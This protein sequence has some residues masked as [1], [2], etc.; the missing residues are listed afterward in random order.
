MLPS[1]RLL[2]RFPM[3]SAGKS[4]LSSCSSSTST[5]SSRRTAA[6]HPSSS[7][8]H[9]RRLHVSPAAAA[10]AAAGQGNVPHTFLFTSES[11]T[12]GHPDKIC[13]QVSDAVLDAS[14]EQDPNSKVACETAVKDN[15]MLV[16]GEITSNAQVDYDAVARQVCHDIGYNSDDLG[17]NASNME[18]KVLIRQQVPEIAQSVHGMG[19]KSADE[20]GAGDQGH[21]FGYASDETPEQMPLSHM[22]ASQLAARLAEVRKDGTCPWARPDGKTQVTIEYLRDGGHLEPLRVHTLLISTQHSPDIS[23]S[24]VQ[25]ELM[26]HVVTPVIPQRLLAPDTQ[27]F[28][29]PSK[30]FILG[31]PVGDAGLTGRKIIVDTYGGWGAHGGGA[32]SGKD[33]TKVDR[34]AAYIAR[35]AAKSVVAA[36]LAN[37]CQVQVS[38]GIGLPHPLSVYVDT[39]KTGKLPDEA[40]QEAVMAMFDFRPG[41]IMQRLDLQRGGN[42]RYQ[43]TA[44]YGH[45][46]RNHDPD[47]SWEKVVPLS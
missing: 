29:N 15:F 44:A 7:A 6:V 22:L 25:D 47:F 38:Y 28:L 17:F 11:V 32:F 12:E 9:T 46:G 34:S 24:E 2:S 33:P 31:G 23:L 42:K 10:T 35:Q 19:H 13:D 36:G 14:L 37:R 3:L 39:F 4:L 1:F 40:I 41:K 5:S 16:F 43:K 26:K 8:T 18:V 27:Y 30:S 45:F 21:M 20:M